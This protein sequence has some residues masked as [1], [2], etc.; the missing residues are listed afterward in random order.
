MVSCTGAKKAGKGTSGMKELSAAETIKRVQAGRFSF[1]RLN[2]DT[3]LGIKSD[4][5]N[6]SVS[7]KIRMVKD[8]AIWMSASKLGFEVGR[9]LITQDSVFV[10]ERLQ[11]TFIRE[12]IDEISKLAGVDLDFEMIQDLMIGNPYLHPVDNTVTY[13]DRDS[14]QIY[15]AFD[16]YRIAHTFTNG[17]F[18][19]VRT[20]VRDEATKTAVV[21]DLDEYNST[22][23]SQI[24]AYFR[25][26]VVDNENEL[27]ISFKDVELNVEKDIRF[28]I[29]SSYSPR[30]F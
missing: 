11:K 5:F 26:I 23:D 17:N 27:S 12:S 24:F 10:I 21:M 28:S 20:T 13:F 30:E 19:L 2:A 22:S 16:E 4:M 29:P 3:N 14:L 7:A 25:K 9:V 8:S 18:R 6:G 15:P 1:D